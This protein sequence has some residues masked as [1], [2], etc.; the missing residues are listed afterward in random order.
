MDDC[1]S[2]IYEG[3]CEGDVV[4]WCENGVINIIDCAKLSFLK[5]CG[6]I[7]DEVG[8]DCI[9]EFMFVFLWNG[10][11]Y[12]IADFSSQSSSFLVGEYEFVFLLVD[13]LVVDDGS[14]IVDVFN[15]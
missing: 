5:F 11:W 7:L 8:Y 9:L 15:V 3:L 6:W 14:V 2:I 10:W 13:I 12:V 4:M 1:G